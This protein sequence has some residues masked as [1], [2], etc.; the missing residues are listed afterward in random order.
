VIEIVLLAAFFGALIVGSIVAEA[1]GRL[2]T[3]D[4]L[5]AQDRERWRRFEQSE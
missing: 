5:A 4:Q 3:A 1:C 2:P